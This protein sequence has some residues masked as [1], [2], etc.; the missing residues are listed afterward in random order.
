[1]IVLDTNVLSEALKPAPEEAVLCWLAEQNHDAAFTTATTQAEIPYEVL[2]RDK[3]R[4]CCMLRA[5][6]Y[7]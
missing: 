6:A 5:A 4:A 2:A 7:R 3:R 1:M